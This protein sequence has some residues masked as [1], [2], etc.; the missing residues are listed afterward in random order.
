MK[1]KTKQHYDETY[2][3]KPPQ[4]YERYFVP[5]I[6]EPVAKDL[7][8]KAEL[9]PGE[10]VLDVACGTGIIARLALQR[11]GNKGTVTGTDI[12]P[13]MLAVAKSITSDLPIEWQEA[14]AE[15]MPFPDDSFD[16]LFC[17]MGLQFMEDKPS[18]LKEMHRVL[19]PGGRLLLNM[20]GPAGEPFVI[21]AEAMQRNIGPGAKEFVY[22]VFALN[23]T[24]EIRQLISDAGF[25]DVDVEAKHKTLSL[26][27]PKDFLWQ[28]VNST[29]LAGVLAKA[30][31]EARTS[32]EKEVVSQW[33]NFVDDGAFIYDQ[34]MVTVSAGK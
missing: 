6:G 32:L 12:N 19:A 9:R 24:T 23:D 20:P 17:Q 1:T 7:I 22:D 21:F 25:S 28:Y 2:G 5:A 4:N 30:D 33:Q 10:R 3:S 16:V 15:D 27:A 31:D 26:P 13:G 14:N 18:A 11:V 29:P 8:R 34:R